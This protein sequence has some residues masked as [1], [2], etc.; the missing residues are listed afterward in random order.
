MENKKIAIMTWHSYDNYGSVLQVYALRKKIRDFGYKKVDV[1]NY[2]PHTRKVKLKKRI[3]FKNLKRKLFSKK[4]NIQKLTEQRASKYTYFRKKFLAYTEKCNDETDLFLLNDQ[5]DKFICGSDQIWAPTVFDKNYF[6]D[7]VS[8]DSKKIAYAPSIGLSSI[9]NKYVR[10]NM[11]KLINKFECLSIREEQGKKIIK[12]ITD[13]NAEVVLDPTLLLE[14]DEWNQEFNL[15]GDKGKYILYYCLGNNK[16]NYKTAKKIAEKLRKE[17]KVIPTD[18]LDYKKEKIENCGPEEFLKL[19]YNAYMVITDS[20]HGTI[21]SINFNVP[22]I[23]FKRFK[24]NKFSQNSRIYNIL[25]KVNLENRIY[26]NNMKYFLENPSVDFSN[27]NKIIEAERKKSIDFLQKSIQKEETKNSQQ[28]IT[29]IC[30]G[31]GLCSI[32]CPQKCIN[33]ELNE[34]GFYSYKINQEKCIKCNKCK[35]VCGQ[36]NN[37]AK[38]MQNMEL[39]S[40]YSLDKDVLNTSSS[41]G[42]AYEISLF[43]VKNG[44]SVIG[45]TYDAKKGIAKHIK[46]SSEQDLKKLSGSKY[47]QS[48]TKEAFEELEKLETGIVIGTPCQIA[49]VDRYLKILKKRDKFILIDLICHGVPSYYLWKKYTAT[50]GDVKEVK[51]RDKKYGWKR[52]IM[53]INNTYHQDESKNLFYDFFETNMVFNDSCYECKYRTRTL[54]DIRIGDY[55]GDK[56]AKEQNGVSM[57]IINTEKGKKLIQDLID[58]NKIKAEKQTIQDYFT[59]QQTV[60]T[61]IPLIQEEVIEKLK[62]NKYTLK[63][64]S[65]KYCKSELRHKK[66]MKKILPIYIK[67][68]DRLDG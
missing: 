30:T 62:N 5:Y 47:L 64:I 37:E 58:S 45:C 50:F 27:S 60:N 11:G 67:I 32:V 44:L 35:K 3:T 16:N 7:F 29:N 23:A 53:T 57:V 61:H 21:F 18:I 43:G 33:I 2:L 59:I 65:K 24:D 63:E 51:F 52:K 1:I 15:K 4:Q 55:W 48:F 54:A 39:Y 66:M 10:E 9:D 12:N 26:N 41:G 20:F 68:K 46:V 6:L 49:S 38:E 8:N 28:I 31:C 22:F 19:I 36:L 56:F 14:K 13:K 34:K 40:A 25:K 17:L 42:I